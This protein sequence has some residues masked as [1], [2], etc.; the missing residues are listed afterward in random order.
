MR[1][2]GTFHGGEEIRI[3]DYRA[4]LTSEL[5]Y[6]ASTGEKFVV[7]EGFIYDGASIPNIMWGLV[8]HPFM[9]G[10]IRPAALHDFLCRNK[11]GSSRHVHQ[12]FYDGLRAEGV[13]RLYSRLLYWAVRW[14]G[15]RFGLDRA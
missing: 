14:F 6:V 5:T 7:P 2:F 10:Y 1:S 13:N 4:T 3:R 11:V 8:G 15:P 9:H 12:I